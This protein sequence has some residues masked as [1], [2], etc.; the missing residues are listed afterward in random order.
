M[1]KILFPLT[2]KIHWARNQILLNKLKERFDV[3]LCFYGE[4]EMSMLDI[5]LD[6]GPKFKRGLDMIKPDLV[7]IRADRAELLPCAMLSVYGGYPIAQLEAGDRSGT[8]DDKVRYAISHLADIHFTTN[9]EARE[10]LEGMGFEDVYNCGSLDIE[11]ALSLKTE[12]FIKEPY[13]VVLYHQIP[14]E[15]ENEVI[16]A[17]E[18]FDYKIVG[19]KGNQDYNK[20]SSYKEYYTPDKF[21]SLLKYASCVVGNSSAGLKEAGVLGTPVVNVGKR[22]ANRLR[23]ENVIDCECEKEDI[24]KVVIHQLAKGPYEPDYTYHREGASDSIVKILLDSL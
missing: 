1:K 13:I 7:L 4:K 5:S 12:R 18:S 8:W 11:Y 9:Y 6:I 15:D 2:S 23:S 21:I 16:K 20:K 22:Q 19:I 24:K 17:V 10:R 14:G 3:H